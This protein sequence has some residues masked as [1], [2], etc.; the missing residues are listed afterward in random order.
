MGRQIGY[1]A[2]IN[3]IKKTVKVTIPYFRLPNDPQARA[4]LHRQYP[5]V[6]ADDIRQ[7]LV[8]ERPL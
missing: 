2:V 1:L 8:L 6:L 3:G 4:A 7:V 5:K